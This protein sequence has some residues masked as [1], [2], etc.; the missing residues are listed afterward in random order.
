MAV[1]TATVVGAVGSALIGTAAAAAT[2]TGLVSSNTSAPA[3]S[4]VN[5][6]NPE[7]PYGASE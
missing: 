3:E 1:T 2:I 4:P 6:T 5:V 7:V